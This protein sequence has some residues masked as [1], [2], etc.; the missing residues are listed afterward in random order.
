MKVGQ[1]PNP[2]HQICVL[3]TVGHNIMA[4]NNVTAS[5]NKEFSVLKSANKETF[6]IF[7][8]FDVYVKIQIFTNMKN[9]TQ[10][11]LGPS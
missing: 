3:H 2:A 7:L 5:N 11:S 10:N 6:W 9:V 1:I 8:E 4:S